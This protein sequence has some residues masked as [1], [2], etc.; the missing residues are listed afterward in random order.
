MKYS[1]QREKY[2]QD[3]LN[4]VQCVTEHRIQVGGGRQSWDRRDMTEE[5]VEAQSTCSL[6]R[7]EH[8]P[9]RLGGE[10]LEKIYTVTRN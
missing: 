7:L 9:W 4:D 5:L 3:A 1:E 10:R 6:L 2:E 8:H